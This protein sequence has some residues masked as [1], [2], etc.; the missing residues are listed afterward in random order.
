MQHKRVNDSLCFVVG[1]RTKANDNNKSI[2]LS[3]SEH[4]SSFCQPTRGL[5]CTYCTL[6]LL[7]RPPQAAGDRGTYHPL[8]GQRRLDKW[9]ERTSLSPVGEEPPHS[10]LHHPNSITLF[11]PVVD[12]ASCDW[13]HALHRLIGILNW[14]TA[15]ERCKYHHPEN[16]HAKTM[17]KN[18]NSSPNHRREMIT[19]WS[20]RYSQ[21]VFFRE[22]LQSQSKSCFRY[23][24]TSLDLNSHYAIIYCDHLVTACVKRSESTPPPPPHDH[25][26]RTK[27]WQEERKHLDVAAWHDRRAPPGLQP[28]PTTSPRFH[29]RSLTQM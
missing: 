28:T 4:I 27:T 7:L 16:C 5:K 1:N 12:T 29:P 21:V 8:G 15:G 23:L 17:N 26:L 22:Q 13:R 19:I 24:L 6:P 3:S 25:W 18:V 9:L 14:K 2:K 11:M 10:K 20:S